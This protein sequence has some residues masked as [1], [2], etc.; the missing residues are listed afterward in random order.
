VVKKESELKTQIRK[1]R[2]IFE[3]LGLESFVP[4]GVD[5]AE[6]HFPT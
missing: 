5:I 6:R 2:T 1:G 4:Q 3:A